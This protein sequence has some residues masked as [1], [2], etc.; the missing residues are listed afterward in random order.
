MLE[1]LEW[2]FHRLTDAFLCQAPSLGYPL[3]NVYHER[4]KGNWFL[5][6]GR[7]W[8]GSSHI[9][10]IA[11]FCET[12]PIFCK[13]EKKQK[14]ILS[15]TRKLRNEQIFFRLSL[16]QSLKVRILKHRYA[17]TLAIGMMIE[18]Q[19]AKIRLTTSF[20]TKSASWG[21]LISLQASWTGAW[22]VQS[23]FFLLQL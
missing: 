8:K 9:D 14:L 22:W 11:Q 23:I 13:V 15:P 17:P 2:L 20:P 5:F 3:H 12:F 4:L 21:A 6:S 1:C 18:I 10:C 16:N 19:L 7:H